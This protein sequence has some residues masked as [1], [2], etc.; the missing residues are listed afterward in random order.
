M[1]RSLVVLLM[2][3]AIPLAALAQD[4]DP[5]EE[6]GEPETSVTETTADDQAAT[7]DYM[8]YEAADFGFSIE[9]PGSGFV[10]DPADPEWNQEE[11]VAFIW[12]AGS[13]EPIQLI[14]GRVDTFDAPVDEMTFSI[15]CGTMLESWEDEPSN[16]R[17][18]TANEKLT[19]SAGVGRPEREW[20]LI[21]IADTSHAEGKA[22]HYSMFTTYAGS[23]VYSVTMYYM[24][25]VNATIREFGIPVIYSFE[26]LD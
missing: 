8:R 19:T 7:G 4:T 1:N 21:E 18:I 24:E 5:G 22:I 3:L 23:S 14:L 25:P 9:L 13:D 11:A 12:E 17:I 2:A 16:Y 15:V 26:L 10:S 6:S 20:N